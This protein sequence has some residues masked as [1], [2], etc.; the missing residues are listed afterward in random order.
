MSNIVYKNAAMRVY[1]GLVRLC[2]YA[3]KS[4]EWCDKLWQEMLSDREVYDEFVYYL[5]HHVPG[6]LMK[7]RGYSLTDLYVWQIEQYNL[8]GDSGKNTAC[9]NKEEMVLQAFWMLAEM[10]KNPDSYL[11]R[12]DQG[13][14]MDKI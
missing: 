9:C 2:D 6:D 5:E 1:D 14:G 3:G 11:G 7:V 12:L 10:K 8:H 13:A 4:V